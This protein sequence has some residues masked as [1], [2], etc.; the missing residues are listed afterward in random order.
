MHNVSFTRPVDFAIVMGDE[1]GD[2][3]FTNFNL[4]NG[5]DFGQ[6]VYY[7]SGSGSFSPMPGIRLTQFDGT[8]TTPIASVSG[9]L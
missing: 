1:Y 6:G 2:G 3:T 8:G 9:S 4:G 7:L 5:Y